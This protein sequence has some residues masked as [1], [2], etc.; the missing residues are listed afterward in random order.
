MFSGPPLPLQPDLPLSRLFSRVYS[1]GAL[2]A[3]VRCARNHVRIW[4]TGKS[5]R[6]RVLVSADLGF[7]LGRCSHVALREGTAAIVL[8]AEAVIRWRTLQVA[9]AT[10]YLSGLQRLSA[11]FP[12]LHSDD[13][14][15]LV[16]LRTGS[17]EEVLAE[18]LASGV[19]VTG[20]RIVYCLPPP[21]AS[22]ER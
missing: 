16:P 17:P 10:P 19:Q 4:G 20:S 18:C 5:A 22:W 9:T 8:E 14:G 13:T 2:G 12:G 6:R 3:W 21:S 1:P 11:Q 7:L 15:L